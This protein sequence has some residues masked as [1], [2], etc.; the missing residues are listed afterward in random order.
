[1]DLFFLSIDEKIILEGNR[2]IQVVKALYEN[3]RV[4]NILK[5]MSNMYSKLIN[6]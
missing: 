1:L 4:A 5:K 6:N 2:K 3:V